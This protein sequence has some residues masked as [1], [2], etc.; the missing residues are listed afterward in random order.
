MQGCLDAAYQA[1]MWFI[2]EVVINIPPVWFIARYPDCLLEDVRGITATKPDAT[3]APY[4][5]SP[6]FIASGEGDEYIEAFVDAFMDL[7]SQYPNVPAVMLGNFKINVLPWTLGTGTDAL[8]FTYWPL[9]DAYAIQSYQDTFGTG[10]LPPADWTAY[11]AMSFSER[12]AFQ[13]WLV[14]AMCDNLQNR[15][16]P[17]LSK[18]DGYRV[19][20]AS[21]W[22]IDEVNSSIFTTQTTTMTA[23]KQQAIVASGVDHVIINDD[24][25]GDYGLAEVQEDDITLAHDNGFLIYGER[26]P[27]KGDWESLYDMWADFNPLPDGFINIEEETTDPYWMSLFRSLY[28]EISEPLVQFFLPLIIR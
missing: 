11:K 1:N 26:V 24:N 15:F 13:D 12:E 4:L 14:E 16:M 27:E 28:G 6:W 19:I 21:I 18:F 25:M 3:G 23:A 22:N 2:P 17:W 9:Q 20:N 7:V 10:T 5:L 8:D